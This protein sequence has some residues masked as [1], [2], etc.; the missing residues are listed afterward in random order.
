MHASLLI[1]GSM[2][3]LRIFLFSKSVE[4]ILSNK[5]LAQIEEQA[6]KTKF[7]KYFTAEQA[8]LLL[9]L[10]AEVGTIHADNDLKQAISRAPDDDYLLALAKT[11]NAHVLVTGDRDL[12]VLE[13]HGR[14]KIMNAQAFG[15]EY[16]G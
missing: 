11:A 9:E 5:L 3:K 12:L 14:T 1:G 8:S 13:K 15:K 2:L 6:T 7:A 16:L 4:L 10:L